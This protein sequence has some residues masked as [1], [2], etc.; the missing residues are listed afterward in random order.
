MRLDLAV[1]GDRVYIG[2]RLV[3][4]AVGV[5]DGRIAWVGSPSCLPPHD[6][7]VEFGRRYIILPGMVDIHVHMR[8]PGREYKEDWA[9]GT[10]AA[11]SGGVTL[12]CDMPNNE[13]PT[14][15]RARFLEKLERAGSKALVDYCL[16]VGVGDPREVAG[17]AEEGALALKVYPEDMVSPL[18]PSLLETCRS[19]GLP[20]VVHPEDPL[21]LEVAARFV[22]APGFED[23]GR[24]RP[25]GAEVSAALRF[26]TL[27]EL[28]VR[29][30]VTHVTVPGVL[31]VLRIRGVSADVTPHHALLDERAVHRLGGVAKVNPPLRPPSYSRAIL[32]SLAAG[33]VRVITSDHAPHPAHEKTSDDYSVVPP[34]FPGLELVLHLLMTLVARGILPLRVLDAYSRNPADLFGLSKGAI[35]PGRDADLVVYDTAERWRV[36][37]DGMVSKSK[38]TPFEGWEVRG[39][40]VKVFLRG[41]LAY[42]GGPT[43]EVRGRFVRPERH[44][45][46]G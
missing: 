3:R 12:V 39:R 32:R 10:H 27:A 45:R 42:D 30:H 21:V 2:G 46:G 5:K 15:T 18:L 19:L 36:R 11:L 25:P 40:V 20:V 29:V 17:C 7:R 28:G 33:L 44:A 34:G 38:V 16:Y 23:H 41:V 22:E 1:V 4:A 8:E 43:G 6:E 35:E 13:P 24:L 14:N 31:R 26:A 9:T 37:G